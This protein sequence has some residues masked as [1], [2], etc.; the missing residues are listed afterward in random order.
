[1]NI[2]RRSGD[3]L[4][5]ETAKDDKTYRSKQHWK[6]LRSNYREITVNTQT[7]LPARIVVAPTTILSLGHSA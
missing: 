6:M 4:L 1:M 2:Y 7:M 3:R 5:E